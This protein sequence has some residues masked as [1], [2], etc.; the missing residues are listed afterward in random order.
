MEVEYLGSC[1]FYLFN[2]TFK[3][4]NKDQNTQPRKILLLD[5]F[6]SCFLR[7]KKR[8]E[9]EER[10]GGKWEGEERREE[11]RRTER[12]EYLS[13]FSTLAFEHSS[14]IP[15]GMCTSLR[16]NQELT[17]LVATLH[18]ISPPKLIV[19]KF[20]KWTLEGT[21]AGQITPNIVKLFF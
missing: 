5:F 16:S 11:E 2:Y 3:K 13:D 21:L 7:I 12:D 18:Y 17:M 10:R 19:S 15:A 6:S 20:Y 8:R 14:L 4:I 9:R 1:Y